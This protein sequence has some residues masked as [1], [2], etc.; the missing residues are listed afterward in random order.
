MIVM[1]ITSIIGFNI[2]EDNTQKTQQ[3]ERKN[4]AK[5]KETVKST[6]SYEKY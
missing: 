5:Q 1:T 4:T 3:K 2:I 6:R